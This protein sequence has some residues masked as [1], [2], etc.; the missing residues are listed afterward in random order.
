M[1]IER[2]FSAI[3]RNFNVVDDVE[4]VKGIECDTLLID[5]N[6]IIHNISSRVTK[7]MKEGDDIEKA[8]IQEIKNYILYL[9]ELVK[10]NLVY[11]SFD[12]IPTFSKILEQK[13]RRYIGD[14][15][16]MLLSKYPSKVSFNKSMISTGTVFMKNVIKTLKETNFP[17]KTI[18][19]DTNE[20]GEGEFKIVKYVN[21]HKLNDFII[22]S[23]DADLIIL[24]LILYNSHRKI[25]I[26]RFDQNTKVLNIIYINRLVKYFVDYKEDK[27]IKNID[28]R[29]YILDLAMMFTI[30]GNDFLPRLEDININMDLYLILDGYLINY[31]DHGYI[32]SD[33]L[34]IDPKSFYFYLLFLSKYEGFL[35]KRN[36][37]MAKYQ[38]YNYANIVNL[39]LDA[40]EKKYNESMIFYL[41]LG[42]DLNIND[43]YGKLGYYFFNNEQ[44][45]RALDNYEFKNNVNQDYLEDSEKYQKLIPVEYNSNVRKHI[46][47]TKDMNKREKELYLI[48]KKLDHYNILFNTDSKF[49]NS[50]RKSDYYKDNDP[51]VMVNEYLKGFK[52]LINYY[53]KTNDIDEFWYYKYHYS[54]LLTD[55]VTY[56]NPN[57]LHY[58]FVN[59]PLNLKPLQVLLYTAP[60][61]ISKID[62]FLKTINTTDEKRK[63]I[64]HFIESNLNLFYNLDEI[65]YSVLKGNLKEGL[66]DCSNANFISKCN[67][68]VLDDVKSL[69][70]FRE[71]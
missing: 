49:L 8:I 69:V 43:Q 53:I 62:D 28:N 32:L 25:K 38:N 24:C 61:K 2:F 51:K 31:V 59:K 44:I 60:I 66:F 29:R 1:G 52:W 23:P 34:E 30:F 7:E 17:V 63:E 39:Y 67:Y 40:K 41:D 56:F 36:A 19:S 14:F 10:C 35:L 11:I 45:I 3:N 16:D 71:I 68:F 70:P 46:F 6:S 65:Y 18:I 20:L 21:Q 55:L 64:K 58:R 47:A 54:P 26:L 4:E 9:M 15:I 27:I 48:E 33:S 22:Y 13:R 50:L 12:G 42:A 37:N 5:F 57:C